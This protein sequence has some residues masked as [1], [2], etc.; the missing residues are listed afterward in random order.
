[1]NLCFFEFLIVTSL[2]IRVVIVCNICVA[3]FEIQK[4]L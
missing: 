3:K 4:M 1:M 2:K